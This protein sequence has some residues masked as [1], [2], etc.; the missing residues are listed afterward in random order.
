[1]FR[2]RVGLLP[3]IVFSISRRLNVRLNVVLP[4]LL[5]FFFFFVNAYVIMQFTKAQQTCNNCTVHCKLQQ[6]CQW[7]LGSCH[8]FLSWENWQLRES[9][10]QNSEYIAQQTNE[11]LYVNS[12]PREL[13]GLVN[14]NW[15]KL[16]LALVN[17]GISSLA[18]FRPTLS[19]T[20]KPWSANTSSPGRSF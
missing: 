10:L 6:A 8:H 7:Q 4:F 14:F 1:M 9:G 20:V 15:W 2:F 16:R 5:V 19:C 13:P 12:H 17:G 18:Q 11:P 3:F